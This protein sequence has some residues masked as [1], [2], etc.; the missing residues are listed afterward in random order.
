MLVRWL[1]RPLVGLLVGPS[2]G[3]HITS[4]TGYVAIAL[5]RGGEG[6]GNQL[7]SKTGY[8]EIASRLVTVA[9]S[10]FNILTF[11]IFIQL[12]YNNFRPASIERKK[13]NVQNTPVKS[14]GKRMSH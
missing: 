4:K 8:V 7:M 3:P 12:L 5:R 14:P 11:V 1:V 10:C 6:R 2:V 13:R 9:C